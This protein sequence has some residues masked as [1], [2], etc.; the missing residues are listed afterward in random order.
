LLV[1]YLWQPDVNGIR[2]DWGE[3]EPENLR[4]MDVE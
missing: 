3:L 1:T 2:R 4:R